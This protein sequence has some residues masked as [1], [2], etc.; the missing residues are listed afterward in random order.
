MCQDKM[1]AETYNKIYRPAQ[2]QEGNGGFFGF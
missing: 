1:T 2:T